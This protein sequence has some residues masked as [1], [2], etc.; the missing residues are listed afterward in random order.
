[1]DKLI[2]CFFI[3]FHPYFLLG[4]VN[5]DSITSLKY[6]AFGNYINEFIEKD[7]KGKRATVL[8]ELLLKRLDDGLITSPET[9]FKILENVKEFDEQLL[10]KNPSF[11]LN[12]KGLMIYPFL[13]S[14]ILRVKFDKNLERQLKY[15]KLNLFGIQ[16]GVMEYPELKKEQ[17]EMIK[18][19]DSVRF[20]NQLAFN[21]LSIN[22]GRERY[23]NNELQEAEEY[24]LPVLSHLFYKERTNDPSTRAASFYDRA[25]SLYL[26]VIENDLEKLK[27]IKFPPVMRKL[28]I[29]QQEYISKLKK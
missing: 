25:G 11:A 26:K 18:I 3:F 12:P 24:L 5:V 17:I 23:L 28:I 21:N 1:M 4:Q 6:D 19:L 9:I 29:K 27:A 22:F 20:E 13:D 10:I 16:M 7:D 8:E 2:C 14:L 15:E